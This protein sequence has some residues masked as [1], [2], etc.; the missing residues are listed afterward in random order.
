MVFCAVDCTPWILKQYFNPFSVIH[1]KA[2]VEEGLDP[3]QN[4][5]HDW[6]Q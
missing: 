5:G 1:A 3:I 4:K 2:L 6:M